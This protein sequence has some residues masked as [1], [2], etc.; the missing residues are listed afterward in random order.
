[1]EHLILVIGILVGAAALLSILLSFVKQSPIIALIIVGI[2][3][4]L[5]KDTLHIPHEIMEAFTEIGI[6]LL[7]FMAGLE[8]DF[9]SVRKRW[10]LLVWNGFGQ[11]LLTAFFGSILGYFLLE[12]YYLYL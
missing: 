7:L 6:I 9:E 4:G 11:I 10:K 12:F 8:V 3:V 2:V 1:M 5:F